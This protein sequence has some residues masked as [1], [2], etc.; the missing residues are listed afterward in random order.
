[1]LHAAVEASPDLFQQP[2]TRTLH[3]IRV[4]WMKQRGK[5]EIADTASTVALIEKLLP[6][7]VD[8]LIKTTKAPVRPALQQLCVRDL[9]RIGVAVTDDVDTVVIKAADGDLDK[10]IAALLDDPELE[11]A[12]AS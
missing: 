6:D 3:G 8:V 11:E 5:L 9:K 4:G 2:K 12:V 10:L 1:E 7:Q